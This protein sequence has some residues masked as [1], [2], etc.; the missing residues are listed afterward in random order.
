MRSTF[1]SRSSA[2]LA[3]RVKA[4]LHCESLE[5]RYAPAC[6][7][8]LTSPSAVTCDAAND[9]VEL[10]RRSVV[11]ETEI[12][13]NGQFRGTSRAGVINVNGGSGIN[14]LRVQGPGQ[15]NY[16][17]TDSQFRMEFAGPAALTVNY[18][19]AQ[20]LVLDLPL[21]SASTV[22][23]QSTLAGSSA[24]VRTGGANDT[25]TVR[26]PRGTLTVQTGAGNDIINLGLPNVAPGHVGAMVLDGGTGTNSLNYN[27][28]AN[29][30]P[31]LTYTLSSGRVQRNGLGDVNYA[32]FANA[33]MNL[34]TL[35][36][37]T[38]NVLATAAGVTTAING[39]NGNDTFNV[40]DATNRLQLAGP[41]VVNGGGGSNTLNFRDNGTTVTSNYLVDVGRMVKTGQAEVRH[42][43][44]AEFTLL[45]GSASNVVTLSATAPGF[46]Y[47]L[48]GGASSD[49]FLVGSGSLAAIQSQIHLIGSAGADRL[50]LDNRVPT[51]PQEYLFNANGATGILGG[52][53]IPPISYESVDDVRLLSGSGSDVVSVVATPTGILT[54]L[55]LGG[56]DDYVGTGFLVGPLVVNGQE[57]FDG[58]VVDDSLSGTTQTYT[59]GPTQVSR[60]GGLAVTY[61]TIE[62]LELY[63]GRVNQTVVFQGTGAEWYTYVAGG[64]GFD[65]FRMGQGVYAFPL[66]IDGG[67]GGNLIDYSSRSAGVYANLTTGEA[68]DVAGFANIR[69]LSGG[70]GNDILVG[71]GYGNQLFGRSGADLLIAGGWDYPLLPCLLD[72]GDGADIVIGG[73][74]A[75]DYDRASLEAVLAGWVSGPLDPFARAARLRDGAEGLPALNAETVFSNY[76]GNT[77]RGGTDFDFFFLHRDLD[78]TDADFEVEP[79]VDIF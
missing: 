13:I 77:L 22:D 4:N 3:R 59:V 26:S 7:V 74:T 37:H 28:Q 11:L 25:I 71:N 55:D 34:G 21:A 66:Y 63:V 43:N 79:S 42:S 56:G 72:G 12:F 62:G 68:T 53:S 32:G 39:G 52:T 75:Y 40:G 41:L 19:N 47:T 64:A 16:V 44:V 15:T 6:N 5:S 70:G 10:V 49:A 8:S 31:T 67:E 76:A 29:G 51:D 20:T 69:D 9:N 46:R 35:G 30:T 61:G 24:T 54:T 27:D 1:R 17:L 65:T 23:V 48:R 78:T 57:G 36:R 18:Q 45:C 2:S 33:T 50:L 73:F 14:S 60:T 38:V 58:L